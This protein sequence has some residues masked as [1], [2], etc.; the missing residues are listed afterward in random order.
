MVVVSYDWYKATYGG[1]L[2]KTT[3]DRL[4]ARAFLFA[5]AMTEYRLGKRW[6]SLPESL[7]TGIMTAVCAYVDQAKVEESGGPVVSETNDGISRTYASGGSSSSVNA[8][9]SRFNAAQA[10]LAETIR[11][12]LAPTGL[13]YRGRGR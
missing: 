6:K 13:L 10:R 8:A 7:K 4:S 1:E 9:S 2:D 11:V 5:D 3:F 12:Y